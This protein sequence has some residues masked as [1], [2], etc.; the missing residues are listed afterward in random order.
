M[1]ERAM[2]SREPQMGLRECRMNRER[3]FECADGGLIFTKPRER[4]AEQIVA[5][6]IALEQ[7][8]AV[9]RVVRGGVEIAMVESEARETEVNARI[10]GIDR[11]R[12]AENSGSFVPL[13]EPAENLGA[14][15]EEAGPD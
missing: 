10:G 7:R 3:P 14:I 6:W 4:D 13:L 2:H 12:L 1:P 11:N 9:E 5:T 15:E 8:D